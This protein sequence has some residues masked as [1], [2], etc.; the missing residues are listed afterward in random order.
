MPLA[1]GRNCIFA[2]VLN[3]KRSRKPGDSW[4]SR[5]FLT[6]IMLSVVS[7]AAQETCSTAVENTQLSPD[8]R[9]DL[10][11]RHLTLSEK[12]QLLHEIGWGPLRPRAPV[13][14]D[15]NGGVGEVQG[16][17][18]LAIPSLQQADSAV[19]VRMAAAQSWYATLLP[20]VLSAAARDVK[21]AYL[22]GDVIGPEL[23]RRA[24]TSDRRGH[25]SC[26]R[27]TQWSSL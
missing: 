23:M 27:S 12:I 22:Y 8:Q 26:S 21:A 4:R 7:V 18:R 17:P 5:F 1:K 25:R 10:V 9:A 13:P 16:I 6:I 2:W 14:P 19:G 11:V 3:S 15:N 24:A 20:S